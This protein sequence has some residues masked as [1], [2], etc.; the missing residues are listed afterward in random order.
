MRADKTET[1]LRIKLVQACLHT[2]NIADDTV[3]RQPG[4]HLL[5]GRQGVLHR[6]GIDDE[7]GFELGYLLQLGEAQ[8][9]VGKAQ[10]L[11]ILLVY[12]HLVVEAEQVDEETSHLACSH[13]QYSHISLQ[14]KNEAD[15]LLLVQDFQLLANTLLVDVLEYLGSK[16]WTHATE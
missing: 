15:E 1:T 11:G 5:K 10:P 14:V 13:Y 2:G 12:G 4:Q 3:L 16:L 8:T 9:V 7:L 6:H